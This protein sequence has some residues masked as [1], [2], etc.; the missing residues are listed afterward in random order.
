MERRFNTEGPIKPDKHYCVAPLSRVDW[1]QIQAL[2]DD[3]RYFVWHAPRQTGKTTTLLAMMAAFNAAGRYSCAYANIE[4]AQAER[5]NLSTGIP[6]ACSVIARSIDLCA[7]GS[8]I[9]QWYADRGR[10]FAPSDQL[11]RLLTRWAQAAPKPVVLL[12]DEVDALVGDTLISLLRQIRAG[13][14]QRPENF[15]QS[16]IL[17]GV[18]DVRDY[19][20]DQGPGQV[21]T[22]GGAFNIKAKSLRLGDFTFAET[23]ALWRQ[24][25]AQTGQAFDPAVWPQLWADTEGQ[26]WLVNALGDETTGAGDPGRDRSRPVSLADYHDARERLIQSR[27]THLDQLADKLKEPRVANVVAA[28]L[29]GADDTKAAGADLE[30]VEDLGLVKLRPAARIANRVY[31]EIIPRELTWARQVNIPNQQ[32][33]WY[34]TGDH[35]LDL[36]AL[37]SGFQQ[38]FRDN[39]SWTPGEAYKEASAQLLLQAFLQRVVNGDGRI[40]REYALGRERTDLLVEWPLDPARGLHG[41]AQR[42]VIETKLR[43]GPLEKDIADGLV[44]VVGYLRHSAAAEAHLIIFD[45]LSDQSWDQKIWRRTE[46]WDGVTVSVWGA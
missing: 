10:S 41:P 9:D 20:I 8:G 32:T 3:E 40:A 28:I 11:S 17:G 42:V 43:R 24:H 44:Q 19:R 23:Q 21:I 25:S 18:R 46:T 12:L 6:A 27:H 33:A 35:R 29:A 13:H 38:F 22:G 14:A 7:P 26:P 4:S 45:R 15:P 16:V 1:P 39:D 30:Y 31:Q 37:L 2:V 36:A 34:L 5:G